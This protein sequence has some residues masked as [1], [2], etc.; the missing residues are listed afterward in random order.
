M[1]LT[2]YKTY[3]QK[4]TYPQ[5][6]FKHINQTFPNPRPTIVRI[7]CYYE[8]KKQKNNQFDF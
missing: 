5:I 1:F 7:C 3:K 8:I 6:I 2:C 4:T